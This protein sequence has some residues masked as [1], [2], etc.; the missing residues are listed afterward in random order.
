[1]SDDASLHGSMWNVWRASGWQVGK[2]EKGIFV[3]CQPPVFFFSCSNDAALGLCP[4]HARKLFFG[5]KACRV[6]QNP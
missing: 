6:V 1:M 5:K 2:N 4:A 3:K